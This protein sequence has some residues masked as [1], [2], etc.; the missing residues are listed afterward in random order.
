MGIDDI[1]Q[2]KGMQMLLANVVKQAA[3]ELVK[4]IEEF[5]MLVKDLRDRQIRCEEMLLKLTGENY[6]GR[7]SVEPNSTGID[8]VAR[9]GAE[10]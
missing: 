5:A 10:T 9:T 4:Q 7:T 6:G 1:L 2:T 3:P 8:G